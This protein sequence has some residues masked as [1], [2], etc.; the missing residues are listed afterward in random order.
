MTKM[1][2]V[3]SR[4]E[5]SAKKAAHIQ[6]TGY[7]YSKEVQSQI[8]TLVEVELEKSFKNPRIR[9]S[10]HLVPKPGV[11][12]NNI[13]IKEEDIYAYKESHPQVAAPLSKRRSIIEA[14]KTGSSKTSEKRV[15]SKKPEKK[16]ETS[17]RVLD[18]NNQEINKYSFI[19]RD[20]YRE[21]FV[22]NLSYVLSNSKSSDSKFDYDIVVNSQYSSR[23]INT[24]PK[25]AKK[26]E[27]LRLAVSDNMFPPISEHSTHKI[28]NNTV[29][30]ADLKKSSTIGELAKDTEITVIDDYHYDGNWIIARSDSHSNY[31]DFF[32]PRKDVVL[33]EGVKEHPK[34]VS[35]N[36][37][38]PKPDSI[39]IDWTTQ[40]KNIPY[41]DPSDAKHKVSV[42]TS[43]KKM[44]SPNSILDEGLTKGAEIIL[45]NLGK[46]TKPV[47]IKSVLSTDYYENPVRATDIYVDSRKGSGILVLVEAPHRYVITLPDEGRLKSVYY[48][49]DYDSSTLLNQINQ[50]AK[51]I[52][53]IQQDI[54]K[55]DGDVLNFD[56]KRE[57][58]NLLLVAPTIRELFSRNGFS[59]DVLKSNGIITMKLSLIHI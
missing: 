33:K 45:K 15:K 46:S 38:I 20:E 58:D 27:T 31:G 3:E 11:Y 16:V 7:D 57:K 18:A 19:S 36:K 35:S 55:Y 53:S 1:T 30:R 39:S 8:Q 37:S 49:E 48:C 44:E 43:F 51:K 47:D 50:V 34:D 26:S 6:R 23:E 29:A 9:T 2:I 52:E 13:I 10:K 42:E 54:E 21:W 4:L 56:T 17:I 14:L 41:Y 25:T 32:V 12:N 28:I 40:K 22:E 5:D 59:G 24:V